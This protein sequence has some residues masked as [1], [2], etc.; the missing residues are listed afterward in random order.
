MKPLICAILLSFTTVSC[1][2]TGNTDQLIT[3]SAFLVANK[4]IDDSKNKEKTLQK[5]KDTAA[6]LRVV[7]ETMT[8]GLTRD[9][10]ITLVSKTG[11]DPELVYLATIL[12]DMYA[13]QTPGVAKDKL[14]LGATMILKIAMG[15]EDAVRL[16]SPPK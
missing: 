5:V 12:F 3:P 8:D 7:A 13:P 15:L 10:F 9:N 11:A 16:N 4:V 2:T 1:E 14:A 6:L